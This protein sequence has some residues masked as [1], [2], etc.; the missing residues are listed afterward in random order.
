MGAAGSR[1]ALVAGALSGANALLLPGVL[2]LAKI[3]PESARAVTQSESAG[4]GVLRLLGV[5]AERFADTLQ[6]LKPA[7]ALEEA[8]AFLE[9]RMPILHWSTVNILENR[10]GFLGLRKQ[11]HDVDEFGNAVDA[12]LGPSAPSLWRAFAPPVPP[13]MA[14]S[15]LALRPQIGDQVRFGLR[16]NPMRVMKLAYRSLL[17]VVFAWLQKHPRAARMIGADT[18]RPEHWL[19]KLLEHAAITLEVNHEVLS[20]NY[21][22]PAD[23][24]RDWRWWRDA[25]RLEQES[26]RQGRATPLRP[27]RPSL[28]AGSID[29]RGEEV[30]PRPWR[31][32]T[33]RNRVR[34]RTQWVAT[35][36]SPRRV[37]SAAVALGR[38][39]RRALAGADCD[40]TGCEI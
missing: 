14:E 3:A 37:A 7:H 17:L 34:W 36:C 9:T 10:F 25:P 6:V 39:S 31:W 26:R 15:L 32:S 30:A 5:E 20:S 12:A 21:D 11:L 28:I 18:D 4:E 23:P 2:P 24:E 19:P 38:N 29:A 8:K 16:T 35:Q 22:E 40:M 13:T 27:D 1:L 33:L